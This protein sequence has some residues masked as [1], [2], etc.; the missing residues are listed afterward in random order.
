MVGVVLFLLQITTV[1][2]H[3]DNIGSYDMH[4]FHISVD[5][6]ATHSRVT[7]SSRTTEIG[8][9]FRRDNFFRIY[10]KSATPLMLL[11]TQVIP[12]ILGVPIA[13]HVYG[14]WPQMWLKAGVCV[15]W[16]LAGLVAAATC[17]SHQWLP[18]TTH[19]WHLLSSRTTST[20]VECILPLVLLCIGMFIFT[21]IEDYAFLCGPLICKWYYGKKAISMDNMYIGHI[22]R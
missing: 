8:T 6:N 10:I 2:S 7:H 21:L 15:P 19:H 3:G 5:G 16:T 18:T 20:T 9:N 4:V 13:L 11:K 1:G 14:T 17:H 12:C 22:S